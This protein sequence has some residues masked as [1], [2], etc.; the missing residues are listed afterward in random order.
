MRRH[1]AR[2]RQLPAAVEPLVSEKKK[3]KK[4]GLLLL[5]RRKVTARCLSKSASVTLLITLPRIEPKGMEKT[6]EEQCQAGS[7]AAAKMA[8]DIDA[9][10]VKVPDL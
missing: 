2:P 1:L 9:G 6:L 3:K 7:A 10:L 4:Q 5:R 8:A